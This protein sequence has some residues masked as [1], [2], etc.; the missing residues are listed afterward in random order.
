MKYINSSLGLTLVMLCFCC[1]SLSVNA[2]DYDLDTS[3][4]NYTPI[5]QA[6]KPSYLQTITDPV[7]GT[8]ITRITGDVGSPIPNISGESWKNIARHGYSNR[9]PWNA[10]ES[11]IYLGKHKSSSGG[12]GPSLFLDGET[13]EVIKEAN[14]ASANEQR[15][16]P[17]NP[18]LMLLLRDSGIYT[19][20]YSTGNV[21]Q[22]MSL[23]GYSNL[24]TGHTGNYTN[25]GSMI[26]VFANRNSD[27][28][29]VV[30]AIDFANNVKYPDID[31]S[32]ID[33]DWLSISPLGNYTMVNGDYGNGSDRTKV[34]DLQGNQ[35]GPYWSE[36][37]RPSHFDVAVDENGIEYAVGNS[38]SRPDEG[39]IIKRRLSDGVV[40]VLSQGGYGSHGSARSINRLGWVFTSQSSS[41]NWGPYYDEL[42][43]AKLDGTRVERIASIRSNLETYDNETQACPSPSGSRVIYASDWGNGTYPIQG[44]IVDFRDKLSGGGSTSVNAGTDKNICIGDTVTLTASGSQSYEWSTGDT[45]ASITVTPDVT[46]TYT[47]TGT[48]ANGDTTT[49]NVVVTVNAIPVANAGEDIEICQGEEITLTASGGDTYLWSNGET[50]PSITIT[51]DIT[52]NYSV[53]VTQNNCS[54]TDEVTVAVKPRQTI[55]AGNDVDIYL[56]ESTT[57]T[58][59]AVGDISWSTGETT[60]SITVSP[61]YTTTY[62]VEATEA[63][64]CTAYDEVKVTV[65]GTV[66]PNAGADQYICNGESATLTAS[67]GESYLWSTGETTA[68]IV[69]NPNATTTYNVEVTNAISSGTDEVTVYVNEI[70]NVDAGNDQTIDIGQYVTLSATGADTYLWSNGATQP[71]IAVSPQ[72]TTDYYVTGFKN[73]C[74]DVAQVRVTVNNTNAVNANAGK[75]QIICNGDTIT[76]TAS[77]GDEYLWSTGET[78]RIINV[79]PSEDTIYTV[80]V[81]NQYSSDSDDVLVEVIACENDDINSNPNYLYEIYP[82]PTTN[83]KL[84]IHLGGLSN[85]SNIFIHDAIGKLIYYETI[86]DNN[87]LIFQKEIDISRF[88]TGLYFVTLEELEKSTTKKIIFN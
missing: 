13:Y 18:D 44:Y 27:G 26:S 24:S 14:T 68:T 84:K 49:D 48:D 3:L 87:G 58:V 7:F 36:Y 82:N 39:R 2:Q 77:G 23:S 50:T 43:A 60:S 72:Q 12:W 33:I 1:F 54:S 10:D 59:V 34:Y 37:G 57:L 41:S 21:N 6:N 17:T 70:P 73:N 42:V 71:N 65:I 88:N 19:W 35:V 46:T 62:Y 22:L 5:P 32:G 67:G 75:D 4:N 29:Q 56:G 74:S 52:T 69:V 55:N 16:H 25:D 15:W 47:V 86:S 51:P 61:T 76:L 45:T 31:F 63:N 81:S 9:Q 11:I 83:G 8:K 80:M 66:E 64:G 78:T 38:K 79:S 53:I 85:N 30:F 40:T 28:K 20:S